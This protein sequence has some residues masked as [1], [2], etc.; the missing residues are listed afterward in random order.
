VKLTHDNQRNYLGEPWRHVW[1]LASRNW[2][3]GF[4]LIVERTPGTPLRLVK[5]LSVPTSGSRILWL[6]RFGFG[7]RFRPLN[8]A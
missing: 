3:V 4:A 1:T 8:P 5:V 7:L 6:W 2:C